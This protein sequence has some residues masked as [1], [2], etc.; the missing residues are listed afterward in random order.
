MYLFHRMVSVL[1]QTTLMLILQINTIV[2]IQPCYVILQVFIFYPLR[3]IYRIALATY[4]HLA[5]FVWLLFQ[6]AKVV[7]PV[8]GIFSLVHVSVECS[9]HD[10]FKLEF[11]RCAADASCFLLAQ[12]RFNC[13]ALWWKGSR[14][15][16]HEN[17]CYSCRVNK[18]CMH[19]AWCLAIPLCINNVNI[20]SAWIVAWF[21]SLL[22]HVTPLSDALLR[23]SWH[24]NPLDCKFHHHS[25][26]IQMKMDT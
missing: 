26:R 6:L 15:I 25:D 23:S 8:A 20:V 11:S 14:P 13:S 24:V 10:S 12:S 1:L 9:A 5:I 21:C 17:R 7:G 19:G 3:C 2:V 22:C 4:K 16:A 18:D